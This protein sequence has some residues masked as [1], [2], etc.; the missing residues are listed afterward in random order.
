MEEDEVLFV[1]MRKPRI[2]TGCT[3]SGLQYTH[4]KTERLALNSKGLRRWPVVNNLS[5]VKFSFKARSIV[6]IKG[7]ED[8]VS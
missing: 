4:E 5:L 2:T 1:E 8:L 3:L 7:G 6:S